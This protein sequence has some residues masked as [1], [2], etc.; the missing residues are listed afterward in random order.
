MGNINLLSA[1]MRN[2]L[3]TSGVVVQHV[4]TKGRKEASDKALLVE[5]GLAMRDHL[6][7]YGIAVVSGDS[8]F[9]YA[10]STARNLGYRT[11]LFA[12]NAT[13][14]SP[15]LSNNVDVLFSFPRDVIDHCEAVKGQEKRPLTRKKAGPAWPTISFTSRACQEEL[16]L[17]ALPAD[18]LRQE[19]AVMK[20][21]VNSFVRFM[22][23]M[24]KHLVN[25]SGAGGD[26]G[27]VFDLD[28]AVVTTCAVVV[29]SPVEGVEAKEQKVPQRCV[30]SNN[31]FR[32][33][34]VDLH[35][36]GP[37]V[38]RGCDSIPEATTRTLR[39]TVACPSPHSAVYWFHVAVA[40]IFAIVGFGSANRIASLG[41]IHVQP[42]DSVWRE[43]YLL[44]V[45]AG[46]GCFVAYLVVS[47]QALWMLRPA[48]AG[49]VPGWTYMPSLVAEATSQ[50]QH[51]RRRN[52]RLESTLRNPTHL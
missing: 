6:P 26:A 21:T 39:M 33:P 10:V 27:E 41:T 9:S 28:N 20:T 22:Q 2:E 14:T 16:T 3:H 37:S 24:E 7:P 42:H 51:P 43:V 40:V 29:A 4:H 23:R 48:T 31:N 8:D 25:R 47:T 49:A 11:A 13:Q 38:E 46:Q 19:L 50:A 32:Q 30:G 5:F 36:D 1:A 45:A 15:L 17:A 12:P 44:L 35:A 52:K 18:E 34:A